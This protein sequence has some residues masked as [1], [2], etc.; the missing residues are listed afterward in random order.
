MPNKVEFLDFELRISRGHRKRYPVTV[1]HSPVGETTGSF[2]LPFS[3]TQLD[4]L[5]STVQVALL[6]SRVRTRA[7]LTPELQKIRIFGGELFNALFSDRVRSV[8]DSSLR[9]ALGQNKGL[10]LKLRVEPPELACIPWE[11]LYDPETRQFLALS[12]K[13][14]LIRYVEWPYGPQTLPV[15]LPLRILVMIASPEDYPRL[16]V[17][18]ETQR[19]ERSLEYLEQQ[20]L[21]EVDTMSRATL[22]ALQARLRQNEYHIFHFIGHGAYDEAHER[23]VLVMEDDHGLGQQVS[24]ELLANLLGDHFSLRLAVLNA[25]DGAG[26][27]QRAT[28]LYEPFPGVGEALVQGCPGIP[29]VVAMQFAITDEAALLFTGEFYKALIATGYPID[30]AVTEARKAIRVGLRNTIEWGTPVLY[31]RDPEG[32]LFDVPADVLTDVREQRVE[33]LYATAQK[34]LAQGQLK[35]A[36]KEL[37]RLLAIDAEHV[38][39]ARCLEEI[40]RRLASARAR[41]HL[42]SQLI[43]F[44]S[45]IVGLPVRASRTGWARLPDMHADKL[46]YT[47]L[48]ATVFLPILAAV[49]LSPVGARAMSGLTQLLPTGTPRP[50]SVSTPVSTL[51]EE[52]WRTKTELSTGT[53]TLTPRPTVTGTQ[54]KRPLLAGIVVP[55]ALNVRKTPS[56]ESERI[57]LVH[58]G[59]RVQILSR[60]YDNAWLRVVIDGGY[61]GY[62][63]ASYI[64]VEGHVN[65]LE[66]DPA[67]P[68]PTSLPTVQVPTLTLP[69]QTADDRS[70]ASP[71]DLSTPSVVPTPVATLPRQEP[72]DQDKPGSSSPTSTA[73]SVP[74]A[75]PI[76]SPQPLPQVTP[77]K[78]VYVR[79]PTPV[80]VQR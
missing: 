69:S 23:G 18:G 58:S 40:R 41:S 42:G 56:I 39:A 8:Y 44:L 51:M 55:A 47:G 35:Q 21:V 64:K 28:S 15:H 25:C 9:F 62:V 75:S 80:P 38:Q 13:T 19:L 66:I 60:T 72:R 2:V 6:L 43:R 32:I 61:S 24:G 63:V 3:Q 16:D 45:S 76:P 54:T 11:F 26:R 77:T 31:M 68:G 7:T 70:L 53:A 78:P 48:L 20:R 27:S 59:D 4:D 22:A 37:Q 79:P 5:R 74:V 46:R 30:A 50:I 65:E 67:E 71:P 14:P 36:E 29:A 10:R 33:R 34:M 12:A 17:N 57:A 52:A 1:L 49:L 73:T